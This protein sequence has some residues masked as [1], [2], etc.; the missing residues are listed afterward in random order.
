MVTG[1]DSTMSARE[2]SSKHFE[3]R[4]RSLKEK[5]LLMGHK[6]ETMV[7]DSICAH[8]ER[9]PSLAE[10]VI[11]RDRE[12]DLLER[13]ID[14][15]CLEILALDQPVANDL[16]LLTSAFKIVNDLERIGDHAVNIAER[17]T[18][19]PHEPELKSRVG[20][21]IM[22]IEAQKILKDSLDALAFADV[23]VAEKVIATD[24]IIDVWY[25]E[26]FREQLSCMSKERATVHGALG[27]VL[28]ARSLERI[29][30]HSV[31]IAE[32][33][34]FLARGQDVRHGTH[35]AAVPLRIS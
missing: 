19:L 6:A 11:Q 4:L 32:M 1:K 28:M 5:L 20:I 35:A 10:E 2:H 26:V 24:R 22:A 9:R 8:V 27:L 7:S 14:E 23:A 25:E 29:G 15:H 18:E 33:V 3:E 12:L 13:E 16:R 17:A 31:N 21:S 30:D 34:I